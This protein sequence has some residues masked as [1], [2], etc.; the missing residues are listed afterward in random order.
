MKSLLLKHKWRLASAAVLLLLLAAAVW[1]LAVAVGEFNAAKRNLQAASARLAQLNNRDP[2]PSEDNVVL[3]K[4]NYHELLDAYNELNDRLREGQVLPR[5]MGDSDFIPLLEN[6]LRRLRAG[7]TA[8]RVALPSEFTF[9]FARYAG[10]QMPASRDIPRLVQQ[11]QIM[12]SLCEAV[13][14]SRMAELLDLSREEFEDAGAADDA[15][16]G[17]RGRGAPP[18]AAPEDTAAGGDDGS[19]F[20]SQQFT[21]TLRGS[22]PAV[23]EFL[24]KVSAL[25]MF[26]VVTSVELKNSRPG[27][28]GQSAAP[29]GG[30]EKPAATAPADPRER[31]VVIGREDIE[32]RIVMDV[33]QFAPSLPWDDAGHV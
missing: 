23:M 17:R 32:A 13:M 30:K 14:Q 28:Q 18:P 7:F 11:L 15:A 1:R 12:E 20:R 6:T 5:P 27:L 4:E 9:G 21:M 31:P 24:N 29:A 25:P 16:G 3:A 19:L 2:F 10:G 33:Y 8:N 26:T 22:E